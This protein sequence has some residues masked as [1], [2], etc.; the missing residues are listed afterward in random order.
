MKNKVLVKLLLPDI[1]A[2]YD[3]YF[4]LNKTVGNIIVLLSK[5]INELTNNYTLNYSKGCL[6]NSETGIIYDP[7][8]LIRE[9]NIRNGTKIILM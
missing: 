4:P 5:S 3:I 7:K 9:S 6:Y 1:D 2:E 8:L